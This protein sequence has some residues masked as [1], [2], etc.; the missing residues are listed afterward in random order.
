MK[1][2]YL[3][4]L[5]KKLGITHDYDLNG[6]IFPITKVV[7]SPC[8]IADL[9]FNE[10]EKYYKLELASFFLSPN[11]KK[12]TLAKIGFYNKQNLY[13]LKE[14]RT[15]FISDLNLIFKLFNNNK[16]YITDFYLAKKLNLN[17]F[18]FIKKI[19]IKGKTIGKGFTGNIKRNN[20]KRGPMSHGSKNHR[21]P[22]SI[23]A[24][25]TPGRVFKNKRMAG[26]SGGKNITIKNVEI[27]K[28]IGNVLYVKGILP[29][30][31]NNILTLSFKLI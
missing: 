30:K 25:T 3:N 14:K 28:F 7:L 10:K 13:P 20:F 15:S 31:I 19:N 16:N 29:G 11:S 17:F 23:G 6:N 21:L 8:Y 9:Q 12:N 18:N 26:H 5:S 22:G 4:I 24:S 2:N 27:H 1:L